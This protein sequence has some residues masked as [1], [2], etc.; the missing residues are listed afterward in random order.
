MTRLE[1][2]REF[3]SLLD[4]LNR[5]VGGCRYLRL[6]NAKAGWPQRGVYFFLDEHELRQSGSGPR[7]VRV[8]THAVASTSRTTLW[9]RLAQHRGNLAGRSAGGGNHR[10]SIFRLH[11]GHAMLAGGVDL[12]ETALNWG[13]DSSAA[14]EVRDREYELERRVSAYIGA[15]PMLWLNVPDPPGP[16]S[17]RRFLERRSIALLSGLL[18]AS[19]DPPSASWLGL[20]SVRREIRESGLWNLDHVSEQRNQDFLEPLAEA[21]RQV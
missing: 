20:R 19:P 3:Y 16:Q 13:K 2:I 4:E 17:Q 21:I 14:R 12:G 18:D 6:C 1:A 5:R 10:G 8:G 15:L 9:G 7:V 11:V